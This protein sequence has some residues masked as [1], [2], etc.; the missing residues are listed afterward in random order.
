MTYLFCIAMALLPSWLLVRYFVRSD[1]F[2]EPIGTIWMVFRKG[3]GVAFWVLLCVLPAS[4]LFLDDWVL[5]GGVIIGSA[6]NAFLAAAIPEEFFKHQVLRKHVAPHKDFDEPMDGVVYGAVASLGFA[7]IENVL[8]CSGGN[9]GMALGRAFTAVPAHAA[10]GAIMGYTFARRHFA[11]KSNGAFGPALWLPVV[12]HGVYD[13]ML[14][15]VAGV[16]EEIGDAEATVAQEELMGQ[17]LMVFIGVG[18]FMLWKVR[19]NVRVMRSEQE[20]M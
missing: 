9:L 12:L 8:Y 17:C 11:G 10:F 4:A 7:T 13:W 18:I 3:V 1:K 6:V 16:A 14:F 15:I 5:E 2:P 19:R 20:A